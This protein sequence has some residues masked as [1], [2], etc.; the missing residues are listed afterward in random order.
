M[1]WLVITQDGVGRGVVALVE[2]GTS[3]AAAAIRAWSPAYRS[4]NE[5][6]RGKLGV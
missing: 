4:R 6:G 3:A 5:L 1:G 2:G